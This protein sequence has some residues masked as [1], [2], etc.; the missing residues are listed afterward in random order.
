M[1]PHRGLLLASMLVSLAHGGASL[2]VAREPFVIEN[3]TLQVRWDPE[4]SRFSLEHRATGNMVIS[5]GELAVAEG[6]A[7][8]NLEATTRLGR[9]Q[10]ILITGTDGTQVS[11]ALV[12]LCPF[13]LCRTALHNPGTQEMI[14]SSLPALSGSVTLQ[15]NAD[16]YRTLGTA[17]LLTPDKNPGSYTYLAIVDP[18]DRSGLVSGWLTQDRGNGV[19]FSPMKDNSVEDHRV[20]IEARIDYGRLQIAPGQNAETETFAVGWFEDAR[21]GLESF[22]D[23]V[24]HIYCIQLP[25]QPAGYCTW[26]ADQ[27]GGAC[28]QQ[29]LAELATCAAEQLKPYGFEFV[30]IDDGWQ[31]GVSTNGPCRNFTAHRPAG[32]YADGMQSTAK[33]I[34]GLGLMPGIWF[35]PFAGTATDP[36]FADHQDWFARDAQGQPF[37]TTWGGTCL[38]MTQEGARQ[39]LRTVVRQLAHQW[40]YR[41]FKMDGLW[42]GTATRLMYVNDGYQDDHMG[43]AH[44][45]DPTKTQIQAY[46]D[47]L[48]L[49][50]QEAGPNVFLLGCCVSQ[51]MRSLGG[52][53][54]LVDAM[55]VGPDTGAGHIGAPHGSRNYFLHGRV[56]Y[57]DPDCVSVRASTPL[58]QAQLNASWTA[59]S[60][61]LFYC[62]DWLPTLPAERLNI[63]RR[64]M[65]AHGLQARPVDLFEND[66]PRIWTLS[67]KRLLMRDVV[68]LYNWDQQQRVSIECST[69]QLGLPPAHRYVAFDFWADRFVPPLSD[70]L[71]AELPAASCRILS[72]RPE[73][74]VP[75]LIST[76]RHV[77]Q[78][79]VDVLAEA[80]DAP[81]ATLRGASR[82]VAGDEYELRIVVP[83]GDRSWL[84]Q[85]IQVAEG[86]IEAGVTTQWQQDGPKLRA[87]LKSPVSRDVQWQIRFREAT[88]AIPLPD[89]VTDVKAETGYDTVRL[90]WSSGQADTYRIV[91]SDGLSYSSSEPCFL[92][93]AVDHATE[94]GYTV[95][96]VSWNGDASPPVRVVVR[97]PDELKAPANPPLPN[98]SLTRLQ[99]VVATQG[100]GTLG[101]NTSVEGKPLTVAGKSYSEGLGT[102]APGLLVYAIPAQSKRFVALVGL[103]DEKQDDPR[104]SVTF[105]IYGDVKEMG[106]SPVLLAR[107]PVLS[108]KTIRHWAFDIELQPRYR[109]LRL[110]ITDAGDGMAAD[111]ADLVEAGFLLK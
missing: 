98:A 97:T 3:E 23:A 28:D 59:V 110:V 105:E 40:G 49:V 111:H 35:M 22:A 80:W 50:R 31:D 21:D 42:T 93:T 41:F 8:V 104:S 58:H 56:W 76:S 4:V 47:G 27:Y 86:D 55:R 67:D 45:S 38:D 70:T 5:Q 20:R 103:D 87:R 12:P 88:I 90:M 74:D 72:V 53:F 63:L 18:A 15:K 48:K 19:V 44:L 37:E 29:H 91:R 16:Q 73:S 43:E 101:L 66:P 94:Y 14:I 6:T 68:A 9:G 107:S 65:P 109:E 83:T 92:D 17:G 57:N 13:L 99:P 25:A 77:T 1:K 34:S 108:N 106:E 71:R 89:P 62:S 11:L 82:V 24:A 32:P 60:G 84:A 64:C 69:Q 81:A 85:E 100:W 2:S 39:H 95:Q 79:V 78:G 75:Q 30:Q 96:A 46:R 26:Y 52:S 36:F 7:Q 33:T 54:G 102:H 51:N 10:E 61:Q